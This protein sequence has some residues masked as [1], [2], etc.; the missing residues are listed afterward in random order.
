[1]TTEPPVPKNAFV[2]WAGRSVGVMTRDA[3]MRATV[4][5]TGV[6]MKGPMAASDAFALWMQ[7]EAVALVLEYKP[8]KKLNLTR[9]RLRQI[10]P[11]PQ[12]LE[13]WQL[14]CL[15]MKNSRRQKVWGLPEFSH[16]ARRVESYCAFV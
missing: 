5:L 8:R 6:R 4:G 14:I 1:M 3:C 16:V 13:V 2:V 12:C 7:K 15:Q 9:Q 10:H 11:H